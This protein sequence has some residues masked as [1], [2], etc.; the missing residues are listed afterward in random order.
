MVAETIRD[1]QTLRLLEK[2]DITTTVE[3]DEQTHKY[4]LTVNVTASTEVILD[5]CLESFQQIRQ[6]GYIIGVKENNRK[7]WILSVSFYE[8]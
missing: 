4:K 3:L 1:L 8:P 6:V 2:K 7:K 5:L